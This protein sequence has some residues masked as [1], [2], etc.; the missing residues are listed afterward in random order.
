MRKNTLLTL[1][2][3]VIVI[4]ILT[5]ACKKNSTTTNT[6]KYFATVKTILNKYCGTC[7]NNGGQTPDLTDSATIVSTGIPAKIKDRITRAAGANGVM[8]PA[9]NTPLTA[10]AKDTLVRWVNAGGTGNN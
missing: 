5:F 1:T 3:V 6:T 7:H 2:T 8:P 4:A 9:G 10:G